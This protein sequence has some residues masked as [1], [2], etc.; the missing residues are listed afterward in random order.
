[1]KTIAAHIARRYIRGA[2]FEKNIS[3]MVK[4]SFI[5]IL[6]GSFAL[7]LVASIMRGFEYAT[8][9]KM[10]SIHA[11]VIIRSF[12]GSPLDYDAIAPVLRQEFGAIQAFGPSSMRQA[13]AQ[14]QGS[15]DITHV[16]ALKGIDPYKE[17]LVTS[18]DQKIIESVNNDKKI[19][20]T[21]TENNILIGKTLA[22]SLNVKV[23]DPINLLFS[24]DEEARSRKITLGSINARVG[25]IFSTGID[26][27]DAGMA[28]C[29]L[30][31]FDLTFPDVGVTQIA[32]KLRPD[33]NEYTLIERL[34]ERLELDVYSW[35][36]LYPALVA[37]LQLE[38]I[39]MF[40]ILTLIVLVAT[41]NI[42]SLLF[43]QI[44]QKR[45]DIAI[46]KSLG[47]SDAQ[48]RA[49][50]VKMGMRISFYACISGL[51]LATVVSYIL[52]NYPF[53]TLP[54]AYYVSHVPARMEWDL[55]A[56][57]FMV[58]MIIAYVITWI[59]ARTTKHI[60]ISSVLRFEA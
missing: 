58:I 47:M 38:K 10:Q 4:V 53:I 26:E 15:D 56:L 51:I 1:M 23:G 41:M 12:D 14:A 60:E 49:I 55:L 30:A 50:F 18:F 33:A 24:R 40:L 54:D 13:I 43:M 48:I 8:H 22:Q 20:A 5:S 34:K 42:I 7:A 6:I 17:G 45:G 39:A 52:E 46:L 57:V 28:V 25:G 37:A 29:S 32:L 21:I 19:A 36:S 11:Q 3:R 44:T 35:K 16:V 59:T 9:E 27:F 31:F 2:R